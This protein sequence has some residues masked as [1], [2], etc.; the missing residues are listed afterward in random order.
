L[1][2]EVKEFFIEELKKDMV[3]LI[4][5]MNKTN[6][7]STIPKLNAAIRILEALPLLEN[8]ENIEE[9]EDDESLDQL[10]NDSL[11]SNTSTQSRSDDQVYVFERSLRGGYVG[12]V[13][14]G[15]RIVRT[16][17]LEHLDKVRITNRYGKD[18]FTLVEKGPG[19][20]PEG[21]VQLDYCLVEQS[22]INLIVQTYYDGSVFKPLPLKPIILTPEIINKNGIQVGDLV[23]IAYYS[24]DPDK[25]VVI[26]RHDIDRQDH[27][28]PLPSSHYK[29]ITERNN[30]KEDTQEEVT[31]YPSLQN[32]KVLIIGGDDRHP[33][34]RDAI[35][36]EG[37]FFI[38]LKGNSGPERVE[39]GVRNAD[40]VVIVCNAI[41][42]HTSEFSPG[43]CKK[44]K[45]SF[46]RVYNDGIETI[47]QA[48][49][50][51]K[52]TFS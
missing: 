27:S 44:Y 33:D 40:V 25:A 48:A 50:N 22:G 17:G 20:P 5:N 35:E 42:T 16:I 24:D 3:N 52:Y 23:D 1:N 32:K 39:I 37:G 8:R 11:V 31:R 9:K 7:E 2:S 49:A 10:L 19:I 18:F 29:K 21:R 6:L 34:Y 12:D 15:E 46:T 43:I 51:P 26:W 13:Y 30:T 36:H 47:L 14:V 45:V 41:R 38:G 4:Q 28:T